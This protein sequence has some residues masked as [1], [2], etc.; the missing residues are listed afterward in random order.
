MEGFARLDSSSGL[1]LKGMFG[2][3]TGGGRLNDE[4]WGVPFAVF[5]PYSNTISSVENRIRYWSADVGYDWWRDASG[6]VTPFVGYTQFRETMQGFGCVQIANPASDCSSPLPTSVLAII[7]NDTWRALR[8]GVAF[9]IEL[10]PR[11]SLAAEAAYLPRV[12]FSGTDDH[13]LRSLLSP[14]DG[15]GVGVQL[16]V[17]LSYALTDAMRVGIGGRYWSMWTTTGN[18][19]FGGTGE[20]V[21]MRY[22]VE[23]AQILVQGSYKFDVAR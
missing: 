3:A 18:V 8:L 13:V 20:M 19:N 12:K 14:E 17:M 22:A 6:R 9:D 11:L 21:P 16:E 5:V 10:A 1:M 15:K 2:G 4:D 7:E 23:Q